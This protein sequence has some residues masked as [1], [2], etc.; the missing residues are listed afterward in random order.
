MK[1][2]V[3]E[4]V[5]KLDDTVFETQVKSLFFGWRKL[6]VHNVYMYTSKEAAIRVIEQYIKSK[7]SGI[8]VYE[9]SEKE[10]LEKLDQ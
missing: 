3:V 4:R 5:T 8:V 9:T 1:F 2:R 10:Y 7:N 6:S